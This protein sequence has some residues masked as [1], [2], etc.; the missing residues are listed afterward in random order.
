MTGNPLY[1]DNACCGLQITAMDYGD[2]VVV[3]AK[4]HGQYHLLT[5]Y[6]MVDSSYRWLNNWAPRQLLCTPQ[7]VE[8]STL[9]LIPSPNSPAPMDRSVGVFG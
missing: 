6:K 8:P 1:C 9:S 3:S 4:R 7:F 5:I 2:R